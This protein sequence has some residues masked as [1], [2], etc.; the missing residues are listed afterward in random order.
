MTRRLRS[1][2][3]DAVLGVA[4]TLADYVRSE[5]G[6]P[7]DSEQLVLPLAA[8]SMSALSSGG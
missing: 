5:L 7:V 8:P 3:A 6:M 4:E 1:G 2:A